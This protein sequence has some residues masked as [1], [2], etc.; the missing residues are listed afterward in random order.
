MREKSL[1]HQERP[2]RGLFRQL[3][4]EISFDV[5]EAVTPKPVVD[6]ETILANYQR[7]Y[8]LLFHDPI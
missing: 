7:W 6:T 3:S 2:A 5:I 4:H 1:A 8:F